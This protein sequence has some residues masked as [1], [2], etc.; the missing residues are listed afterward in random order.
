MIISKLKVSGKSRMSTKHRAWDFPDGLVI[1]ILYLYCREQG[2]N[3][4]LE[5]RPNMSHCKA[6]NEF[7]QNSVLS[8]NTHMELPESL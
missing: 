2:F 1:T 7:I 4:W 8:K 5:P 6:K 3:F